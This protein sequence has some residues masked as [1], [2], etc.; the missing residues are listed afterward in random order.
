MVSELRVVFSIQEMLFWYSR[1]AFLVFRRC[2][3]AS[4]SCVSATAVPLFI[5]QGVRERKPGGF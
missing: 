4:N 1:G 5:S 2:F 3:P